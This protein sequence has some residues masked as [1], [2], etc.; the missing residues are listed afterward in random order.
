MLKPRHWWYRN[1][2]PHRWALLVI[3]NL[4][5]MACHRRIMQVAKHGRFV[6]HQGS[7][8]TRNKN[9]TPKN[10]KEPA[11]LLT[12]IRW[13]FC[14]A[15]LYRNELK[16]GK[17]KI[18][19]QEFF[20]Q[21]N[22]HNSSTPSFDRPWNSLMICC[23]LFLSQPLDF[24]LCPPFFWLTFGWSS[25]AFTGTNSGMSALGPTRLLL[26]QG[27]SSCTRTGTVSGLQVEN[28]PISRYIF[29]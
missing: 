7:T 14:L 24:N 15:L 16:V 9:S 22:R 5:K 19:A 18:V 23:D 10:S 27:R 25:K 17:R 4:E 20:L 26:M 6:K 3:P 2:R 29:W 21:D 8:V 13:N 1:A 28:H 11:Y 12:D